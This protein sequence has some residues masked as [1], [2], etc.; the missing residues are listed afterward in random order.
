MVFFAW[1]FPVKHTGEV[2]Q[3]RRCT[4]RTMAC[5]VTNAIAILA[6]VGGFQGDMLHFAVSHGFTP[7]TVG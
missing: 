2:E 1:P 6:Q 4:G 3:H 5:T 7:I